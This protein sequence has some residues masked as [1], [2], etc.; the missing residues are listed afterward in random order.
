MRVARALAAATTLPVACRALLIGPSALA[1]CRRL[2]VR[3]AG[4]ANENLLRAYDLGKVELED[5]ALQEA[6][7][8]VAAVAPE[9]RLGISAGTQDEATAALREYVGALGLPRGPLFGA[10]VDGEPIYVPGPIFVKYA[11][12]C[13]TARLRHDD[14]ARAKQGVLFYPVVGGDDADGDAQ[15]LLPLGLFTRPKLR[16]KENRALRAHGAR[17]GPTCPTMAM[18]GDGSDLGASFLSELDA[19]LEQ[20]ELVKVKMPEVKKKKDAKHVADMVLAPA[21]S[22]AERPAYTAHVIG[23]TAL[24]YRRSEKPTLDLDAMVRS[25]PNDLLG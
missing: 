3:V 2:G 1:A 12:A 22:K 17:L 8:S 19:F 21:L 13:G 20:H 15:Y 25:D 24:L 4:S 14:D 10:D 16:G 18:A 7:R 9:V 23:H 6:V 11:S 5:G